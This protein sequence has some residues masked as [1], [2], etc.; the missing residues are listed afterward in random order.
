MPYRPEPPEPPVTASR[1]A[2]LL[3]NL[4]TPDAPTAPALRRYLAE[5]LSDPRVVEIPGWLWKPILYGVIL[6]VRPA[7]SAAKYATVWTPEGSP[8]A[9]W[10]ARQAELLEQALAA[11]GQPI[12]VR[13]AMRYGSPSIADVLSGLRRDGATRILV[14]PLYPQYAGATTGSVFDAVAQW[15]LRA[16]HVPEFRFVH[17]YHDEPAYIGALAASVREHWDREGRGEALVMSFHGIP[18]RSEKL[19]DPYPRECRQT[20]RLLADRLGIAAQAHHV[21]FQSRFGKATWLQPYTEPTLR[22]LA[23]RGLRT[24]DVICPGFAADCLET[25]EEIAG[26][27]KEAFLEA[28]GA[29][30]RYIPCLN[31]R[32]DGIAAMAGVIERHLQGWTACPE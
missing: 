4:G 1:V 16:R 20:A 18:E 3:V 22:E 17:R 24:V 23:R 8:L 31:D 19:G 7:K 13:P 12:A 11:R 29:A 21:T 2:V 27:A 15:G 5:F 9:V 26:E 6:Q 10:T 30:L 28:G 25:L 32:A 14:F